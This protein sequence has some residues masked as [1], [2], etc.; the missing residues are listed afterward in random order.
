MNALR[1]QPATGMDR[2][3]ANATES[4]EEILGAKRVYTLYIN[5]PNLTSATGSWVLNFSELK[6]D[7]VPDQPGS[8]DVTGPQPIRKVDPRYPPSLMNAH[9]EGEVVLYAIIRRDGSVD[10]IQLM[11]GVEGQLDQN[12]MEA[13]SRWKFRPARRNGAPIELEAVIHIPFRASPPL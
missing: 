9:V 3:D 5:M 6:T 8:G 1:L 10:S 2:V 11:K 13:F 12:A 7:G 4:P